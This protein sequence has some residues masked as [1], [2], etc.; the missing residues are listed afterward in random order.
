MIG[1]RQRHEASLGRPRVGALAPIL[2]GHLERHF[3]RGGATV[4]EEHMVETRRRE[5][6][7][8]LGEA[9]RGG[10]RSA[11]QRAMGHAVE[12]LANGGVDPRVAM[13]MD[14]A[15]QAAHAIEIFAPLDVDERRALGSLDDQ[16]L[17]FGHLGEGMPHDLAIPGSQAVELVGR[18]PSGVREFSW[19]PPGSRQ[20]IRRIG[21]S[22]RRHAKPKKDSR[23]RARTRK[24]TAAQ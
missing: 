3:H 1:A 23:A 21:G 8:S 20:W 12:L 5:I 18:A 4:G 22:A 15:P 9:N 16:R 24:A 7:Q 14:I 6:D 10:V 11:E 19:R 13:A 2:K 17:V